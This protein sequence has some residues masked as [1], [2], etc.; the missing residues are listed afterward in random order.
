[1]TELVPWTCPCG[2]VT[3]QRTADGI[4]GHCQRCDRLDRDP[5]DYWATWT[6]ALTPTDEIPCDQCGMPSLTGVCTTCRT[7]DLR[8]H[9]RELADQEYM[10]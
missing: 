3:Y 10:Q 9:D 4:S 5:P 8:Q 6:A 1:M 2:A 7:H